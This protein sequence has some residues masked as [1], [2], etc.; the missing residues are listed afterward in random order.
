VVLDVGSNIGWYSLL[1]SRHAPEGVQIF[2]FEPAPANY[3][4]LTE[5]LRRNGAS[6]VTTI[7]AAVG[8][9]PGRASLHLYSESN[10]GRH[11]LLPINHGPTVDV[12]VICL[13]DFCRDRG[14][15]RR[16][17]GFL[18]LDIEGYEY[19]AL[20]GASETLR[21]CRAI[22]TEYSPA[23]MAAA[24]IEPAAFLDMLASAGFQP[25]FVSQSGPQAADLSLL[26]RS[27]EQTDLFWLPIDR[28]K[29]MQKD[30]STTLGVP[31]LRL[32]SAD[33]PTAPAGGTV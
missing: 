30:A 7:Q 8:D 4:L 11:S 1:L 24:G 29:P 23:F 21:R 12:D 17:I 15:T 18:K 2:A 19:F 3:A 32:W 20:R 33:V 14:L 25:H 28:S 31:S 9:A 5:N 6:S 10:R 27:N 13:D 22:L 16:P 26:H